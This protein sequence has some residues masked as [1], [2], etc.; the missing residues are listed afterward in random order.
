MCIRRI[1]G[2]YSYIV[3]LSRLIR[4]L[5]S[6]KKSGCIHYYN[7]MTSTNYNNYLHLTDDNIVG[8]YNVIWG[9]NSNIGA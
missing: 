5:T 8:P 2:A 3:R 1:D 9:P 7:I 4:G 6:E